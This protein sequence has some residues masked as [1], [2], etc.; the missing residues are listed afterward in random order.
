[1]K[2]EQILFGF[3][4]GMPYGLTTD[5]YEDFEKIRNNIDKDAVIKHIEE[6]DDAISSTMST[7]KFT[8][9]EFNAGLYE[10]GE[11]VFPVDFLRYYKTKDIG[12]PKEYEAY[13]KNIL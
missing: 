11:F 10:D 5:S 3:W 12:I 13:L 2:Q 4:D 9:E 8:G 1:M 6:L 7:D